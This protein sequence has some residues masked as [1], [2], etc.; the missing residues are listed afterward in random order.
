MPLVFGNPALLFGAFAAAVPVIIHLLNRRR[1]R[2]VA[3]SD[4]RFLQAE[5]TQQSRR[6]GLRRWLLLLLRVLALLCVALAMARPHWGGLGTGEG[7]GRAVLFLLDASASMQTQTDDGGTRFA[8]ARDLADAMIGALPPAASVQVIT[9]GAAARPLFAAWLPAGAGARRALQGAQATDGP[10]DLAA[11]LRTAAQ[12]VA[13][14]PTTPV[15]VVLLSDLQTAAWPDL[16]EAVGELARVGDAR[17]LVHAVGKGVPGGGVVAVQ[18]PGRALR[19]GET[20]TLTAVVRPERA[21]QPFWLELGGRRVGETTAPAPP[22]GGGTVALTFSVAVPVPGA[23]AGAVGKES[24]RFPA[25]DVR[26]F[27]LDVPAQLDVVLVHGDDRDEIGRGGWRY[28]QGALAPGGDPTSADASGLFRVRAITASQLTDGDLAGAELLAL[29]DAGTLG[30]HL[31]DAVRS[32]LT[33]GGAVLAVA[34]DP[35]QL[36]ALQESL[37]PVLGLPADARFVA[38]GDD[39]TE[40]ATVVDAGDPILADLGATALTTLARASWQR[41]FALGEGGARVLLTSAGGSPLLIVGEVGSGRFALLPFD[42]RAEATDLQLN[43]VFLPLVQ[44][45]AATLAWQAAGGG[46]GALAVGDAPRLRVAPSRLQHDRGGDAADLTVTEPG[47]KPRPAQLVWQGPVPLVSAEAPTR[48]G[49]VTFRAGADT[50]G[51]VA[52]AVPAGESDPHTISPDDLRRRLRDAG[53]NRTWE[54][55]AG[56]ADSLQ[57]AL[58]GTDLAPALILAAVVLLLAELAVGRHV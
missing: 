2:R 52:M 27:V 5:E 39:A 51:L 21:G 58:A 45:L 41:Y 3:F 26:P 36:G 47:G 42:L 33:G 38:H 17:L 7:D 20:A 25:D 55:D 29:V 32:W 8:E 56:G 23:Y 30:R 54:L 18:L 43:P 53:W 35:T 4:L 15:E 40:H 49:I 48:A 9:V 10:C 1:A 13:I 34:G 46:S 37:L 44:R 19:P 11:G 14:A 57:H 12:Q 24:D 22:A 28:L 6:R 50:L 16:D 31:Q